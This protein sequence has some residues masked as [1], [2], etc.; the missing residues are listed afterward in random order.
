[1]RYLQKIIFWCLLAVTC[2]SLFGC[3]TVR[4]VGEDVESAGAAIQKAAE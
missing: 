3:H 1:M 4:G 2:T